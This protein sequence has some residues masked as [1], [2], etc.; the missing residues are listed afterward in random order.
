M[1]FSMLIFSGTPAS[2]QDDMDYF[3]D[4]ATIEEPDFD[5]IEGPPDLHR[6]GL[7]PRQVERWKADEDFWY[8][9]QE[10]NR[11]KPNVRG[12]NRSGDYVPLTRRTWF[13]TMLWL[14]IIAGFMGVLFWFLSENRVGLFNRK[15]KPAGENIEEGMPDDIF[16]IN[17]QKEIDNALRLENYRLAV[18]LMFLQLLK[19]MSERNVI[20]YKQEKTNLDY[21]FEVQPTAYYT[22]F[23][24]VVRN[25]EYSWYGQFPVSR[26][27]YGIIKKDF[28]Q[29]EKQLYRH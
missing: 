26:E 27:A 13:Q 23:F 8:A 19:T 7:S 2:S 12:K 18:R 21:L 25:Y 17:Y 22:H 6:K 16:S 14:F 1:I 24:R 5:R 28:E 3:T 15:T 29:L 9:D 11:S 20:R 4:T 10:L